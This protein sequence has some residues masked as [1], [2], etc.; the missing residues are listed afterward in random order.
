MFLVE[1]TLLLTLLVQGSTA[2]P[3][4]SSAEIELPPVRQE[5]RA[6][7]YGD[8]RWHGEITANGERFEP[9]DY[10]CAHRTLA[11]DTMV[12]VERI[13]T[14][15]RVWCRINDRGPYGLVDRQGRWRVGQAPGEEEQWRGILD[16]S[17]AAG[18]AIGVTQSGLARV[19]LRFWST[20]DA[21]PFDLSTLGR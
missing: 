16:M 7:W 9:D 20:P 11:F 14:G 5:G 10:T 12:L 13:D 1:L 8:G 21:T 3:T 15:Q 4:P 18:H 6:S 17:R 19:R 2:V